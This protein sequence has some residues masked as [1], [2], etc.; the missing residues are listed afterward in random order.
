MDELGTKKSISQNIPFGGGPLIKDTKNSEQIS[1]KL[2]DLGGC[3]HKY[4]QYI[5]SNIPRILELPLNID[6]VLL[7]SNKSIEP[8]TYKH[9]HIPLKVHQPQKSKTNP[10]FTTN[11]EFDDSKSHTNL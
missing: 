8:S 3:T 11:N 9:A 4:P 2:L 10:H 5:S 6:S 7:N 1:I